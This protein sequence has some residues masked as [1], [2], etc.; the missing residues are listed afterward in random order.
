[1]TVFPWCHCSKLA[2]QKKTA[3]LPEQMQSKSKKQ[4]RRENKLNRKKEQVGVN[5]ILLWCKWKYLVVPEGYHAWWC[6][7]PWW[8]FI[9]PLRATFFRG[10]KTY[11]YILCSS[12]RDTGSRNPSSSKTRNE[13][14][15]IVNIMDADVL[16]TQGAR[17][18]AS[19]IFTMLNWI[20]S[21][22]AY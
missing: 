20:N 7:F 9:N 12:S 4:R 8:T 2:H 16:A 21:V 14:F 17:A 22:P 5:E 15:Y 18:S 11:I 1:M 19:I 13:L 6:P 10:N 3:T